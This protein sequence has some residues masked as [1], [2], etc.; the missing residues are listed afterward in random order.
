M[1]RNRQPVTRLEILRERH[2]QLDDI[3]D[4]MSAREILTPTDMDQLKALKIRRLRIKDAIRD[5][6]G[7]NILMPKN[8]QVK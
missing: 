4:E 2:Q 8:F 7:D 5:L 6:T 3:V 1:E